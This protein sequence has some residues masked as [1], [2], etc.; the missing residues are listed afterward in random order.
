MFESSKQSDMSLKFNRFLLSRAKCLYLPMFERASIDMAIL[1]QS[2]AL[3]NSSCIIRKSLHLRVIIPCEP[4][5]FFST[6]STFRCSN[7]K[8]DI[9]C[10]TRWSSLSKKATIHQLT[11]MLST[12]TNVLSPGHNHLLKTGAD[13]PT[14]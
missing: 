3:W 4:D 13:D 7:L 11:T 9:C 10:A 8:K 5:S 12:S 6:L 2:S 1:M 14:D